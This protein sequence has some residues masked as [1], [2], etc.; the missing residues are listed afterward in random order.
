M[1]PANAAV[2]WC[3]RPSRPSYRIGDAILALNP[4]YYRSIGRD[5]WHTTLEYAWNETVT[6]NFGRL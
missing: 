6:F 3:R 2:W 5:T 1:R 4:P